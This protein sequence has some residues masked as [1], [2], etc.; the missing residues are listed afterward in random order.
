MKITLL[1]AA[2]VA[3]LAAGQAVLDFQQITDAPAPTATAAPETT[4]I[5][6][7]AIS[8]S[9]DSVV[10]PATATNGPS[11]AKFRR[12]A[13]PTFFDTCKWFPSK[14]QSQPQTVNPICKYWPYHPDCISQPKPQPQPQPPYPYPQPQPPQPTTTTSKD[15]PAPTSTTPP[16]QDNK[17]NAQPVGAGPQV[18]PDTAEAFVAYPAFSQAAN[19]AVTPS[20][21]NLKFQNLKAAYQGNNYLTYKDLTSYSPSECGAFCDSTKGCYSFDIYFERTPSL[22]PGP[23]CPNPS[24]TSTI[25]CALHGSSI[26]AKGATND[27]QYRES[28]H[29][30]IAGSN[31]YSKPGAPVDVPNC[32]PPTSV[33]GGPSDQCS[34][35][36]IPGGDHYF[37]GPYVPDLCRILAEIQTKKNKAYAIAQGYKSYSPCNSFNVFEVWQD[38]VMVGTYCKLF[39]EKLQSDWFS[40]K[41]GNALGHLFE[42]KNAFSYEFS[43]KDYGTI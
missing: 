35:W 42:V 15:A 16:P 27:G 7:A 18:Q 39:T 37:P 12:D 30:V 20:G 5:D 31:G 29:V 8:A 26:D 24:S 34:P 41:G 2:A 9:L 17:C 22:A 38:S 3:Q 10:K 33:P 25:R 23:N 13:N 21:Y 32:K 36:N 19:S 1:L 40:Y 6:T 28:F 11:A 14:C 43:S 4:S